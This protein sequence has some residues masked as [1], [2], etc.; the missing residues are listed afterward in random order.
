MEGSTSQQ[1][2]RSRSKASTPCE[3]FGQAQAQAACWS[4]VHSRL[5]QGRSCMPQRCWR[6]R[7]I[8]RLDEAP[9]VPGPPV[10]LARGHKGHLGQLCAKHPASAAG[11]C[12]CCMQPCAPAAAACILCAHTL[13]ASAQ[14]SPER[15]HTDD[16]AALA[17]RHDPERSCGGAK[18]SGTASASLDGQ[19]RTHGGV[20]AGMHAGQDSLHGAALSSLTPTHTTHSSRRAPPR[21]PPLRHQPLSRGRATRRPCSTCRTAQDTRCTQRLKRCALQQGQACMHA[22][23][24]SPHSTGARTS[25]PGPGHCP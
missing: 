14:Q 25:P 23:T 9:A 22:P 16:L 21:P 3:Q 8:T 13:G 24:G 15:G 20:C 5:Q 4:C 6:R 19:T 2:W 7:P 18:R 17:Q 12:E 10:S 11:A 1:M